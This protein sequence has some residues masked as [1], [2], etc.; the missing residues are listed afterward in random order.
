MAIERTLSIIKP[1]AVAKNVVGQIL[2]RLTLA[3]RRQ[4][5]KTLVPAALRQVRSW[6]VKRDRHAPARWPR[7]P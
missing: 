5:G 1:D 7:P 2:S 6:R 4:V 3:R